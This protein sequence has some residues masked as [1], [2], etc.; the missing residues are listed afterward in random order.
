MRRADTIEVYIL[1]KIRYILYDHRVV[2]LGK[3]KNTNEQMNNLKILKILLL[4]E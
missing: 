2:M 4:L 3:Y 1:Y